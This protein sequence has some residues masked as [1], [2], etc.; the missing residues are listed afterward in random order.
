MKIVNAKFTNGIIAP[1]EP[2]DIEEGE[3]IRLT[4]EGPA[5]VKVET[6]DA[7]LARAIAEGLA[8]RPVGKRRVLAILRER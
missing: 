3:E 2:L 1:E 6:A 8:T 7:A 4:L 5:E